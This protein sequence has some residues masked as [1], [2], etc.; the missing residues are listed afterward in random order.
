VS[1][2]KERLEWLERELP[3]NPPRFKIHDDL[4]FAVLRYDPQEE[5]ELRREARHLATRLSNRGFSVTFV[6][7]AELLWEAIERSEGINAL[8]KVELERGF[9]VA[10]EQANTYLSD[11][12]FAPLSRLLAER[13]SRLDA[14]REMC[15]LI[16]AAS[17]APD[18]Y[19]VSKLL[20]EMQGKTRVPTIL[21]YP[22][23]LIGTNSLQFMGL[24]DR[25]PLVSYRVKI[26]G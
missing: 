9:E 25:E 19:H 20:E 15:F 1:S 10:Q 7:L 24:P 23:Q 17:L 8:V 13:L 6:S 18:I 11:E 26:Y 5:W 12:D 3:P 2:L 14:D 4:P 22:G 21:F 16:R